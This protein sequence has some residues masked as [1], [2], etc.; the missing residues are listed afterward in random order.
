MGYSNLKRPRGLKGWIM[1][2][3]GELHTQVRLITYGVGMWAMS[4][5]LRF[6]DY[7]W[8]MDVSDELHTL[9]HVTT[10]G[11]GMWA[12]AFAL[13]FGWLRME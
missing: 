4:C 5:T 10:Y 2:V 8:S 3:N 6:G 7:I 11:V 12:L 9:I 1:D 13:R